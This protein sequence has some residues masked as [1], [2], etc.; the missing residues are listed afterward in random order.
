[1]G[2][3]VDQVWESGGVGVDKYRYGYDADG[4]VLW[5]QNAGAAASGVGLDEIYSYDGLSRLITANRGTS[6][7]TTG[8]S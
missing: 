6:S 8:K 4:D 7:P 2:P 1:M 3:S 5:K